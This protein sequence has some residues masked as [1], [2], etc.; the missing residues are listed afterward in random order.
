MFRP[1]YLFCN[2]FLD[3]FFASRLSLKRKNNSTTKLFSC[4]ANKN[5]QMGVGVNFE[6]TN[7]INRVG[8]Y[9]QNFLGQIHNIFVTLG[10]KNLR[11]LRLKVF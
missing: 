3:I 8:K 11:F 1:K 6:Q 9:L 5:V 10:L 4:N 2:F 7:L